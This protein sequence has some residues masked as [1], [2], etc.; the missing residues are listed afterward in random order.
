MLSGR[1]QRNGIGA[2]FWLIWVV[3]A[4]SITAAQAAKLI[5]RAITFR[6]GL[7]VTPMVCDCGSDNPCKTDSLPE[8]A[9]AASGLC[10]SV[11]TPDLL[12]H[13]ASEQVN[14]NTANP[15]DQSVVCP[16]VVNCGS[17]N[18][19]KLSRASMEPKLESANKR[20]GAAPPF[21]CRY[22]A[23]N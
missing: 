13:A 14:A 4:S 16:C 15:T 2:T 22:Q 9:A 11:L 6:P 1:T 3:I 20:Y 7:G 17:T 12:C 21:V 5:H 18:T 19:G 23:C 8:P 10:A